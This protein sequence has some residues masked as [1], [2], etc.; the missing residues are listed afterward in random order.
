MKASDLNLAELMQFSEGRVAFHGRRLILHDLHALGQF[1]RDLIEMMGNEQAQRILTRKGYFWGQS[2][3]AALQQLFEWDNAEEWLTTD[4]CGPSFAELSES[5]DPDTCWL[6]TSGGYFQRTLDGHLEEFCETWPNSGLMRGGK[7]YP[8][9]PLVRRI[10]GKE[11]SL[12]RT[13]NATDGTNGGPN[14][15]DSSG[16]P[17]LSAQVMFPTPYGLS[18]NQGQGDG[19][20]GKAIRQSVMWRTP[21]ARDGDPRGQQSPEKRL[22]GGHSVSLAEQV[23]WPTPQSRDWKSGSTVSDYGNS[24]PPSEHVSGQLN[25]DWVS[26]LMGFPAD[27]TIVEDGSA[28]CPESPPDSRTESTDSSV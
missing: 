17:H 21:Q 6:K 24:R 8:Q 12:W 5:S 28:E 20:F 19:E 25:A 22:E 1:R 9:Q 7:C 27:W 18:A 15:R 13:T 16:A 14:A 2:D 23:K 26:I 4:G 10:S 11:C 3:A